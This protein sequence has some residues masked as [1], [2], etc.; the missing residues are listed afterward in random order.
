MKKNDRMAALRAVIARKELSSQEEV[1]QAM[2]LEGFTVTQS[3]LSRDMNKLKIAK[4]MVSDGRSIYLLPEETLYKR[5]YQA[6]TLVDNPPVPGFLSMQ[7]SGNMGVI[8]TKPGH[9]AS[10][11][12][13]LESASPEGVLG[14]IAG[15]DTIFVVINQEIP[16]RQVSESITA[17]LKSNQ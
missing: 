14:T 9:A 16:I 4:K 12:Y 3:T 15:D 17:A 5:V 8:K 2:A 11:A 1:I 6:Y 10:I 13:H 7:F